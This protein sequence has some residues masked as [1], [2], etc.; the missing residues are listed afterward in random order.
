MSQN[1][2]VRALWT[3]L[4]AIAAASTGCSGEATPSPA[5][6]GGG[7][8]AIEVAPLN[9][10]GVTDARYSIRVTNAADGGGEVVWERTTLTSSQYGDG[11][12]SLTYVGPCDASTGTNSVTVTL[13][14]LFE[15]NGVLTSP[16]TYRN[17]GALTRNVACVANTDVSVAFDV[18][19]ARDAQQGFFDVAVDFDNIFCSAKLDCERDDHTDLELLHNPTTQARDMTVVFGF[20]CTGDPS[21]ATTYLYMNDLQIVCDG[22]GFDPVTLS[23]TGLGNID[24]NASGS[25][26]PDGYLFGAAVYRGIEQLGGMAYWNISLGLNEASFPDAGNCTLTARATASAEAWPQ[27]TSGFPLPEGTVYPVIAWNVPLSNSSARVCTSHAVNALNSGVETVYDGYLPLV[28]A[29]QWS[30]DPVYMAS[31]YDTQAGDVLRA[32]GDCNPACGHGSCD[33]V[34]DLCACDPGWEDGLN[35]VTA[36]CTG[37]CDNG[38]ACALPGSCDCSGTG[39]EGPNCA[40]NIDECA[41]GGANCGAN[42]ACSDTQGSF[43][44]ACAA[45]FEGDPVAGCTDLDECATGNGGCDT[46]TTC[47]NTIGSRTC[48]ACPSGYTGTGEAG[49]TCGVLGHCPGGFTCVGGATCENDATN[50]VWVPPG[51]FWRGC[52]PTLDSLCSARFEENPRQHVTHSNGYAVGRTE[53]SSAQYRAWCL[54]AP[55]VYDYQV[56][57]QAVAGGCQP[58]TTGGTYGTYDPA[59]SK[60]THPINY[61]SWYQA[62]QYCRDQEPPADL[63][64]EAQWE[65]AARGGCEF[66]SS[67]AACASEMETYPWGSTPPTC[68]EANHEYYDG[69]TYTRCEPTTYTAPVTSRPAGASPYGALNMAGNVGE[70][71]GDWFG[72]YTSTPVVDPAIAPWAAFGPAMRDAGYSSWAKYL[73]VPSRSYVT[74]TST[75]ASTGFRCCRATSCP[76]GTYG[77]RCTPCACPRGSCNDGATGDGTCAMTVFATS[78]TYRGDFAAGQGALAYADAECQSLAEAAG[79]DGTFMAWLSDSTGSPSSRFTPSTLA[80][81]LVDGT[82]VTPTYSAFVIWNVDLLH[83]IDMDESGNTLAAGAQ[84]WT[85]TFAEAG[86]AG[87]ASERCSGWT[88]VSGKGQSGDVKA[89]GYSWTEGSKPDCTAIQHLYCVQQ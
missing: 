56:P 39:Y 57:P 21:A 75:S 41:T 55:T 58:A 61:V 28:N 74:P 23:P 13:D 12:G 71:T 86:A 22:A 14:A 49:C 2:G 17:P 11:A 33:P 24:T 38:G 70:L 62:R 40:D 8:V 64:T 32:A 34:T 65:R 47:T 4:A 72:Y 76:A 69:A 9:L 68:A 19:V 29:F 30:D 43:T 18:T 15:R 89:T 48:S 44:C 66:A 6:L 78:T 54:G 25:S 1:R 51:T 53:V 26:D 5:T 16:D 60:T 36:Q 31:R 63:C 46:L 45:G 81:T 52:N 80:Y 85:G 59:R 20:A 37:G 79:L 67:A 7:R 27:T 87:N 88:S 82:V 77:P 35:C 3:T 73:R 83:A 42:A 50:E 10:E 84:A